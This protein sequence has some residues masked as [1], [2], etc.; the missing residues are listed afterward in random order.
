M[1]PPIH[2]NCQNTEPRN[3]EVVYPKNQSRIFLPVGFHQQQQF[4]VFEVA[5]RNP[6]ATIYWHLND[7]YLGITQGIH[8]KEVFCKAGFYTLTL[9]D[10]QGEL[11][12]ITFEVVGN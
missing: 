5:H 7:E 4:S 1:L 12:V 10:N 11:K 2:P 8:K 6:L 9:V 3:M